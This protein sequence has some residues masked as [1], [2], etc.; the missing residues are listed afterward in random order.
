MCETFQKLH[1]RSTWLTY[2]VASFLMTPLRNGALLCLA[3]PNSILTH[4]RSELEVQVMDGRMKGS[5]FV[6]FPSVEGAQRALQ[7]VNG[8]LV[9]GK[10]LVLVRFHLTRTLVTV[11]ARRLRPLTR[12][13]HTLVAVFAEGMM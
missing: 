8:F 5:A 6:R 2:L 9:E 10:P 3:W 1:P 11:Y 12:L 13:T 7:G 4:Y